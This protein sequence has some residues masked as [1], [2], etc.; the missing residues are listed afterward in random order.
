MSIINWVLDSVGPEVSLDVRLDVGLLV[1][2]D[3]GF[4]VGNAAPLDV[5]L[6]GEIHL[7]LMLVWAF[8]VHFLGFEV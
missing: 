2:S 7:V 5:R 3:V 1:R 8:V 4:G 6:V